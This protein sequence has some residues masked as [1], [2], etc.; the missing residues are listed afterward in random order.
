M[1]SLTLDWIQL[2]SALGALHGVLLAG[3]LFVQ[4]RNR[5]ANR[6]LSGLVAACTLYLASTVYYSTPLFRAY[7]YFFGISYPVTWLFGPFVF[8]YARAAGDRSWR[9]RSSDLAHFVLPAIALLVALPYILLSG[10]EKLAVLDAWTSHG[11]PAH[12]AIFDLTKYASGLGYS[13][14]TLLFLRRHRQHILDSYSNLGSVNLAWLGWLSASAMAIWILAAGVLVS[15]APVHIRE[16]HVSLAIALLVYAI[17]YMGLRQPEVF[18]YVTS[19]FP[20]MR[21]APRA[22]EVDTTPDVEP[23]RYGRSGMSGV[24]AARL[25]AALLHIMDTGEPWKDSEL[26]LADLSS[27]LDT[28]P[29]KLSEVLNAQVGQTFHDFVNGY[30][31]REVQRRI[32]GGDASRLKVLA[33]ALDAGFASKSTFNQ[34]FKKHT[35]Q[36]PS[37]FRQ[38]IGA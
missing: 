11:E 34:A 15:N 18:R 14:A 6:L 36:T 2:A 38:A 37:A 27:R 29:H 26:T 1:A 22:V 31:V 20:V 12:I 33:L 24:E 4:R 35:S 5:T 7:P 21:A 16:E 30:R 23:P 8:L 32:A 17:G 28:T 3:V 25:Q 19:E 9:F 13:V 10:P